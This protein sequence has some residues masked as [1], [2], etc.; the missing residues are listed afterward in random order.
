[1]HV[2]DRGN[3]ALSAKQRSPEVLRIFRVEK[4]MQ[5]SEWRFLHNG[6]SSNGKVVLH[7]AD[8]KID[9][10]RFAGFLGIPNRASASIL[11]LETLC[12]P[13]GNIGSMEASPNPNINASDRFFPQRM[14]KDHAD[15]NDT[16]SGQTL[17]MAALA[18]RGGH[19]RIRRI[20]RM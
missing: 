17:A 15:D 4:S 12:L 6:S 9:P 11:T 2:T 8:T 3:M 10:S 16:T 19:R 18:R 20:E 1:M 5:L 14:L 7:H 13:D